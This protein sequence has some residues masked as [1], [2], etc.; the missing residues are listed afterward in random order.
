LNHNKWIAVPLIL[1]GL[2]AALVLANNGNSSESR[3][4]DIELGATAVVSYPNVGEAILADC[5]KTACVAAKANE[6]AAQAAAAE[7][8]AAA[9]AAQAA[10]L[11][12]EEQ[13]YENWLQTSSSNIQAETP[14]PPQP[15]RG[16]PTVIRIAV[17]WQP[18]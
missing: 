6:M 9:A 15:D 16:P 4:A 1:I 2:L 10:Q 14:P 13:A 7:A 17:P 18:E 8:A 12:A 3:L 11:A 5:A